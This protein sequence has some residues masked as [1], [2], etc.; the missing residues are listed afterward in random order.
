MVVGII[1]IAVGSAIAEFGDNVETAIVNI[2]GNVGAI[3][4][5]AIVLDGTG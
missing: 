2:S 4:T 1:A 3:Q 5:E